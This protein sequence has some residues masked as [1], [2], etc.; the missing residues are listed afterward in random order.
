MLVKIL[1]VID[2]IV[3]IIFLLAILGFSLSP[4]IYIIFGVI[5]LAKSSLGMLKDFAS[6]IDFLGGI[7]LLLLITI[8]IPKF[9]LIAMGIMIIQKAFFSFISE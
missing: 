4:S 8:N 1:G 5:L 7:F 3:S 9:M 6:W 2:A